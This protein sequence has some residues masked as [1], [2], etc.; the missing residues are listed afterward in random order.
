MGAIER[1]RA[2]ERGLLGDLEVSGEMA[3]LRD[4]AAAEAAQ[5]RHALTGMG[6]EGRDPAADR[7]RLRAAVEATRRQRDAALGEEGQARGRVEANTVDAEAVA[8]V[9]ERLTAGEERQQLLER[10]LRIY[11]TT[12]A[13]I[14]AAEQQTMQKAARFLEQH[15]GRDVSSLTNGRYRRIQV[16][17]QTL[18]FKVFSAERGDWIPATSL[19]RGTLD[20][21]YLAARLGLVRQLTGDRQPPLILDDPFVTF[22]DARAT[23]AVE[24][25]KRL[26][27]DFQVIYLTCSDRYN[28]LADKVIE[29]PEPTAKDTDDT[30]GTD[31]TQGTNGLA[32]TSAAGPAP[33]PAPAMVPAT[34]SVAA[35]PGGPSLWDEA[36]PGH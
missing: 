24:L 17:E 32:A 5:A 28:R 23:R 3:D 14:D 22:D 18:A 20:Q 33:A 15:M 26:T 7:I 13:A 6:D 12:L 9:A 2:E 10:R 19:S 29:L 21:L 16:D 34:G 35:V 4:A 25:L 30:S 8:R 36:E 11:E 27:A 31:V 1:L